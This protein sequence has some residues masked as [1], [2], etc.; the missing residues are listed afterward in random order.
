MSLAWPGDVGYIEQ[1]VLV[2]HVK[3]HH[4]ISRY[5]VRIEIQDTEEIIE[6]NRVSV[7][8]DQGA[9]YLC[10]TQGARYIVLHKPRIDAPR[11]ED[12]ISRASDVVLG[13]G[14]DVAETYGT[15]GFSSVDVAHGVSRG[16]VQTTRG[17]FQRRRSARGARHRAYNDSHIL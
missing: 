13:S 1:L 8:F 10:P 6:E 9:L 4:M 15:L 17:S 11:V 14:I 3:D 12:V 5:D 7:F 16:G 2:V